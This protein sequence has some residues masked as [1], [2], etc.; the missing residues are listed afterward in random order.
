MKK[1]I[2]LVDDEKDIVEMLQYNLEQEG[3]EVITAYD[4]LEALT[5][6]NERPDLIVLDI[7]MPKLDGF[8]VF[9]KIRAKNEYHLIP[10]LFLTA[11]SNETDEIMGLDLGA[12]DYIQKPI[13]PKLL[14][15]RIKNNLRKLE[16]EQNG[17]SLPDYI[18]IGPVKI[19]RLKYV[20]NLDGEEKI[21]PRKEFELLYFL[22]NNPNRVFGR[23]VLLREIWGADVFVVDRTVD[24]HIRKIREKLDKYADIIET[25]KGV[26]YK[27][28][29]FE[30]S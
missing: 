13:S 18:N 26:G 29:D 21:F 27:F 30:N 6:V 14:V 22:A 9:R 17:K 4:G 7:M 2:L 8:E 5:K 16:P 1:K 28:R 23:E 20:V 3:F 19:D 25:I 15:A 24:V 11:K 10:I 12:D